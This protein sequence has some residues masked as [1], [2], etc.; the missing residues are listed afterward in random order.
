MSYVYLKTGA[1]PDEWTVGFYDASPVGGK[2][3]PESA[4]DTVDR[5][6]ERV[7]YLNGGSM[8]RGNQQGKPGPALTPTP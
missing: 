8:I 6:V 3:I 2:W 1:A 5:A 4:H 7:H